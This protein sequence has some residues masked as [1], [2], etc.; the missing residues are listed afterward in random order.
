MVSQSPVSCMGATFWSS[1][2]ARWR[3]YR[4]LMSR[5]F[6]GGLLLADLGL[7][8]QECSAARSP[9]LPSELAAASRQVPA[10]R[11][12]SGPSPRPRRH[13][14]QTAEA[15]TQTRTKAEARSIDTKGGERSFA[16]CAKGSS[17]K[18]EAE[19]RSECEEPIG[20]CTNRHSPGLLRK[21][22]CLE[23]DVY[24]L[25]IAPQLNCA[26]FSR[27]NVGQSATFLI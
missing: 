12:V 18:A 9:E 1:R 17:P 2:V 6:S 20:T 21:L 10:Q 23:V 27:E 7:S 19:V 24:R 22:L 14:D 3:W 16:V 8:G 4:A 26:T 11:A 5:G 13:A 25:A 15:D